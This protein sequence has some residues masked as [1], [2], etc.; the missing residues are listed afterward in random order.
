[1]P[2]KHPQN[3][4]R[5]ETKRCLKVRGTKNKHFQVRIL[6]LLGRA[7]GDAMSGNICIRI[8]ECLLRRWTVFILGGVPPKQACSAGLCHWDMRRL[9]RRS[10]W[11]SIACQDP[12]KP[13]TLNLSARDACRFACSGGFGLARSLLRRRLSQSS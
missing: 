10:F 4:E 5:S 6:L 7:S 2:K 3:L 11:E 9:I 1:M 12:P 13:R 8:A